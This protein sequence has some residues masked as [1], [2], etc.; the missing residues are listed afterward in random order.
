MIQYDSNTGCVPRDTAFGNSEARAHLYVNVPSG[1]AF[2]LALALALALACAPALA[3]A[4]APALALALPS[5]SADFDSRQN[6]QQLFSLGAFSSTS[7]SPASLF[8][9]EARLS[10]TPRR[11]P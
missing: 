7:S 11:R 2:H 9:P 5:P 6:P 4:W 10:R 8:A 1:S 3:L